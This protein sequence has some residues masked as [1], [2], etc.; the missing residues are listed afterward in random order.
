MNKYFL[1]ALSLLLAFALGIVAYISWQASRAENNSRIEATILLERIEAVM[2]L[3]T[4]E[5]SVSEIYNETMTKEVTLYLPLPT[6]FAFDKKATVQVTGKVLVGYD[7]EKLDLKIDEAEKRLTISAFPEPEILAVD[8]QLAYRNLQESWFNSF[9]ANDY[10]TL[11]QSAK[12]LLR[13]KAASSELMERAR[14]QGEAVIESIRQLAEAAGLEVIIVPNP[15]APEMEAEKIFE[16][17]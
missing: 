9:S 16:V 6:S 15:V 11:N 14:T 2:K 3:V 4:V 12:R 8:H 17:E 1:L 5:G 13:E 7:L 10:T